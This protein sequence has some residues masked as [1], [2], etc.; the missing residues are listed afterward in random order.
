MTSV[1]CDVYVYAFTC[2]LH[3]RFCL[4]FCLFSK[5]WLGYG[6]PSAIYV[7]VFALSASLSVCVIMTC[8]Q[9]I[10]SINIALLCDWVTRACMCNVYT[11]VSL[12][13]QK[14]LFSISTFHHIF[15]TVRCLGPGHELTHLLQTSILRVLNQTETFNV[16]IDLFR[17]FD[18]S[19]AL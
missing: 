7:D 2:L 15:V 3:S 11:N 12:A 9:E 19:R 4:F 5:V 17:P 13:A 16:E 8:P 1:A 14:A 10:S 18:K 6:Y